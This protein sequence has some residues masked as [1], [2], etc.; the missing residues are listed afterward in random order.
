MRE[1]EKHIHFLK[2]LA[3]YEQDGSLH[4]IEDKIHKAEKEEKCV[5]SAAFLVALIGLAS[6]LGIGYS[7]IVLEDVFRNS[8]NT[9][10]K[11]FSILALGSLICLVGYLGYWNR[12]RT[13]TNQLYE[14]ARSQLLSLSETRIMARPI[15]HMDITAPLSDT[16]TRTHSHMG[17]TSDHDLAQAA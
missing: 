16:T 3:Q 12:R 15:Q 5:R 7:T 4:N 2:K 17:D 1:R 14:D 11:L 13:L 6:A 8:T 9:F 10:I